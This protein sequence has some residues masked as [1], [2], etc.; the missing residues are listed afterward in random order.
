MAYKVD[1]EPIETRALKRA[2]KR[3]APYFKDQML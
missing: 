2:L 3:N 1:V